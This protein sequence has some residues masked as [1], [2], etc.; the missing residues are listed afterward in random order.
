MPKLLYLVTED[1]FFVSHFLPMARAARAAGYEVVVATRVRHH[2]Q[3]I[4]SEG[5]RIIA[6]ETKRD[7]ARPVEIVKTIAKIKR[8]VRSERPD[9]VHCIALRMIVLGGVAAPLAGADKLVLAPTGLGHLWLSGGWFERIARRVVRFVIG[10]LLRRPG[11]YY[12]LENTDD[13]T[14]LGI[15]PSDRDVIRIGAGV[16]PD[17]IPLS[18]EPPT[19]PVKVALVARMLR[20]KGISESVDAVHRARELGAPIELHLFG[21]PDLGNPSSLSEEQLETWSR[22][23]GIFWHGPTSDL[24][25]VWREHHIGLLLS[26][27]EGLPR[28]LVEAAAGGRPIVATDVTGC[29]E[30]VRD[31][32]EGFL[33]PP[34]ESEAAA[35]ALVRLA[36]DSELRAQMGQAAHQRFRERFTEE[37]LE[38]TV[39]ALYRRLLES[40]S[41]P[42]PP[43]GEG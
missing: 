38:R 25:K 40:P 32:I 1:W 23:E 31:G 9:V 37:V 19:P 29:R 6:L 16:D 26:Y 2:A 43:A 35:R 17:C 13:A 7:S 10:R 12:L 41:F 24:A 33:V 20:Q 22:N 15:E 30:V 27:R 4:A 34:Y 28:T 36:M 42:P 14:E 21:G 39:G 5:C 8:I 18:P 11:T 3:R